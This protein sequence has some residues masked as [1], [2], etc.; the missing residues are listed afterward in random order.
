MLYQV[1]FHRTRE[2]LKV[3]AEFPEKAIVAAQTCNFATGP[4][5]ILNETGEFIY[6]EEHD[7]I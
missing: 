6:G 1:I 3:E 4:F 5:T 2:E 7:G